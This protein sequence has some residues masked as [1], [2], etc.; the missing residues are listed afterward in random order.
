M[1]REQSASQRT[2]DLPG[3]TSDSVHCDILPN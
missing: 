3:D 1:I 2:A